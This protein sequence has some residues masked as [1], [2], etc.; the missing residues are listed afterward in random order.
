MITIER[1]KA[2]RKIEE[3]KILNRIGD[4]GK[5]RIVLNNSVRTATIQVIY[6][7]G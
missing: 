4:M 2:G 6:K 3:D 1:L 7:R 5:Y